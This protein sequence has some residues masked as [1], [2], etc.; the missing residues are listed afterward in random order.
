MYSSTIHVTDWRPTSA[1]NLLPHLNLYPLVVFALVLRL[2]FLD[3]QL[4][5]NRVQNSVLPLDVILHPEHT[6]RLAGVHLSEP[7]RAAVPSL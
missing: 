6:L 7:V 3:A 1:S 5:V 2:T 4:I